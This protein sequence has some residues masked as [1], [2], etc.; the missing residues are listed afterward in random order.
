MNTK[1]LKTMFAVIITFITA[2]IMWYLARYDFDYKDMYNESIDLYK[3][4]NCFEVFEKNNKYLN[5]CN[6][7][8]SSLISELFI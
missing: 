6:K 3:K 4:K 2:V 1:L 7:S 5:K 8:I